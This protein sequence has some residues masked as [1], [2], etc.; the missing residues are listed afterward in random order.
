MGRL[1]ISSVVACLVLPPY[2]CAARV[3]GLYA[4]VSLRKYPLRA[5]GI[6]GGCRSDARPCFPLSRS[7]G[8]SSGRAPFA[9]IGGQGASPSRAT[10]R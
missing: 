4:R 2:D 7:L 9:A 6:E 3:S 1:L 5:R 10:P 8:R